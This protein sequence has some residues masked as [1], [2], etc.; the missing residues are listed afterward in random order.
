VAVVDMMGVKGGNRSIA[1]DCPVGKKMLAM[2]SIVYNSPHKKA[3]FI[4]LQVFGYMIIF[5]LDIKVSSHWT[6][7]QN[8]VYFDS[9]ILQ[10]QSHEIESFHS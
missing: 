2:H 10:I 4:L 1:G 9:S 8:L 6:S 7:F 3:N 5:K